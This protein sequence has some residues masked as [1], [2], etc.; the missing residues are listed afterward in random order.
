M[1]YLNKIVTKLNKLAIACVVA[2]Q[3]LGIPP[4]FI[5]SLFGI[6][7]LTNL[8]AAEL[9]LMRADNRSAPNPFRASPIWVSLARKFDIWFAF[10]GIKEVEYQDMNAFFANPV[11]G[12][13]KLLRYACWMLYQNLKARD[14]YNVLGN[15]NPSVN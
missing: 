2:L 4:K 11:P 1:K 10:E 14:K 5:A 12:N 3:Q 6:F 7:E 13:H 8:E 15:V 9:K